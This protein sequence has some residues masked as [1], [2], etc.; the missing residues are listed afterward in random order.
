[1]HGQPQQREET[2]A[3]GFMVDQAERVAGFP[4]ATGNFRTG[5][6]LAQVKAQRG[7]AR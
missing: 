5:S 7:F 1:M 6:K 4:G 2:P 3:A